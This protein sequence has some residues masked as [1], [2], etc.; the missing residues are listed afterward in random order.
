M[1]DILGPKLKQY[2]DAYEEALR[3]I[4]SRATALLLN[5][6]ARAAEAVKGHTNVP[7]GQPMLTPAACVRMALLINGVEVD[8]ATDTERNVAGIQLDKAIKEMEAV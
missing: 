4:P 7:S 6:M 2:H 5:E 8:D 1:N 3:D